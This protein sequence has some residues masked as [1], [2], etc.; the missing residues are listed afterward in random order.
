MSTKFDSSSSRESLVVFS[1]LGRGSCA[2]EHIIG[3]LDRSGTSYASV[4]EVEDFC[5]GK[6]IAEC[7]DKEVAM[8]TMVREPPWSL[9]GGDMNPKHGEFVTLLDAFCEE[10]DA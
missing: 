8:G 4:L 1:Y 3:T 10:F 5:T 9:T 6:D 2:P 7:D